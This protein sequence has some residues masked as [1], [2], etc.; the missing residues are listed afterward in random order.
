MA[1]YF[2]TYG[3]RRK[4]SEIQ[5][6][7]VSGLC[8]AFGTYSKSGKIIVGRDTRTSGE[9][10]QKAAVAGLLSA[11]C[12]VI[13]L[14]VVPS[15]TV[16]MECR[17]ME[18]DGGVIITASHN[19]PDWNA[20][21]FMG[22]KGVGLPK[23]K[24]EKVEEIYDSG[25]SNRAS[26][27][28]LKEV[29]YY[30]NAVTDHINKI[31]A[32][33]DTQAVRERKPFV[34]I[35]CANGTASKLAP[36]LFRE[37]GCKVVSLNAQPDGH[38]PG[39]HSEPTQKNISDLISTVTTLGADMGIAWDGD[40]DRVI[41]ID[42]KGGY[43]WGDKS[44]ALSVK[45]RLKEKKGPVVTTVATSN[46]VKDVTEAE[47][48]K[49][50]YVRV[51]AP[52]ISE[53]MLELNAVMGGEEVGGVVWP[54][55]SW[56]KDG[57]MTAAKILELVCTSGKPL[58]KLIAELPVYYN[59]KTKVDTLEKDKQAIMNAV[60]DKVRQSQPKARLNTIDG[61]RADLGGEW[62]I[63]RP[64]GTENY[65]RVFAEA[66]SQERADELTSKYKALVEEVVKSI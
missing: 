62:F 56:G 54:E 11:G 10:L 34:V 4:L 9:M 5:P 63:A 53:K 48:C 2:G 50:E 22:P 55:V 30:F 43:V 26:W 46:V 19:P 57:L 60:V 3:V 44:F 7:F 36:Y 13:E 15:P 41:F 38:F 40:A 37:L 59:S 52:Y 8:A 1:K 21:K 66:K 24:G 17:D 35:D 64:S 49:L 25:E 23:E 28:Q 47:G 31:L 65:V 12:K 45:M 14:G 20:M 42:E 58:S 33:T 61:V 27:N 51:G 16:E 18:C 6:E 39:R 29:T 32:N